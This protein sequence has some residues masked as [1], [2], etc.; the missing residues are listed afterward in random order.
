MAYNVN[1]PWGKTLLITKAGA[2]PPAARITGGSSR[3]THSLF[4]RYSASLS[5]PLVSPG[6]G[7]RGELLFVLS[8][9]GK[10][11]DEDKGKLP[12][13]GAWNEA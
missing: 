6:K 11:E 9:S 2:A 4:G 8:P 13:S 1:F 10:Q 5:F 7:K 3:L 12:Q